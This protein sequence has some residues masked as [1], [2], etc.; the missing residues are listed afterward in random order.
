MGQVDT[1]D[2][3][4]QPK[5]ARPQIRKRLARAI[6]AYWPRW[7]ARRVSESINETASLTLKLGTL[8]LI[9]LLAVLLLRSVRDQGYVIEAFSVPES[10][11]KAGYNGAVV[12]R[13]IFDEV[14]HLKNS[15]G[16][17]K[18]DSVQLIGSDT[19]ELDVAVLGLGL[20]LRSISYHLRELFGRKNR[21]IRGDITRL[22]QQ[23][24]L[25]LR[26]TDFPPLSYTVA[27]AEGGEAA[28]ID[29]LMQMG[30]EGVLMNTDPYRLAV[31]YYKEKR[32]D[33]AMVA[34]R[35]LVKA[36]PDEAH[37]AYLAWGSILE[38][39][40]NFAAARDKYIRATQIR[41]DFDL[42]W[43]RLGWAHSKLGEEEAAI[44]AMQRAISLDPQQ[45]SRHL[46]LAWMHHQQERHEAADS[47]FLQTCERFPAEANC[48]VAWA[49]SKM[50]R[51]DYRAALELLD[52]VK[53]KLEENARSY[54]IR[55]MASYVSGDSLM[56]ISHLQTAYSL[57][58][59]DALAARLMMTIHYQKG[60]Y[61]TVV[62]VATQTN[63]EQADFEKWE[64]Q[65]MYNYLAMAQNMLGRHSEAYGS[66]RRGIAL[67]TSMGYP[68]STLAETFAFQQQPDSFY[69]YLQ[70]ALNKGMDP[71]I[72]SLQDPPY[73][74]FQ[75]AP[76]L[77]GMLI[78]AMPEQEH[79][80]KN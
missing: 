63:L 59:Q 71:R 9:F 15:A 29:R 44:E 36:R 28:A 53:D 37:W 19:P 14:R 67:D 70:I 2:T 26:M 73:A 16:S 22:G 3:A 56:A 41:P 42:A 43:V 24:R 4:E 21:L 50:N 33:E 47:I 35:R 40:Q 76:R 5:A 54:L 7:Q 38:E 34:V 74:N 23:Y 62:S 6:R 80:I 61:P 17:V 20:S 68:Y 12:A 30:G 48:W 27:I 10:L 32:L 13:A 75:H 58:P 46:N 31:V 78:A 52:R 69:H 77:H 45:I 39:E 60:D 66:I 51:N 8:L 65:Q 64:R 79:P 11:D 49:D 72:I 1:P 25:T 57:D 18:A 55:A